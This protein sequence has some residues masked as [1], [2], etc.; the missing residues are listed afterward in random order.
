[1]NTQRRQLKACTWWHA[2]RQ[3][4]VNTNKKRRATT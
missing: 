1:L 2:R 4:A 3:R